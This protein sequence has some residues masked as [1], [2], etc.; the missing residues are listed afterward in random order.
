VRLLD[1]AA[2]T[3]GQERVWRKMLELQEVS[4]GKPP[5]QGEISRAL[6]YKSE[7]GCVTHFPSLAKLG[8]IICSKW[9]TWRSWVAV[10]QPVEGTPVTEYRRYPNNKGRRG[11]PAIRFAAPLPDLP[12]LADLAR[13]P[14]LAEGYTERQIEV[15]QTVLRLQAAGGN[16]P[17]TQH[18]VSKA[19]G[20]SS[21]QGAR[22]HYARLAEGGYMRHRQ[23]TWYAVLP[24]EP[25]PEPT[26][27]PAP[28]DEV[29]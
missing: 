2:L 27:S 7:Q 26:T 24:P 18:D 25:T 11:R 19:L 8:F 10:E 29:F 20:M 6:G 4:G 16:K 22:A 21:V 9:G 1:A 5:T 3:E 28:A 15:W 12:L 17:P 13:G 14:S 23:R